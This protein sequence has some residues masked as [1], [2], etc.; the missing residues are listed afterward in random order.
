MG[1]ERS[2]TRKLLDTAEKAACK[3]HKA[4]AFWR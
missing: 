3:L 2:E 1:L 4:E